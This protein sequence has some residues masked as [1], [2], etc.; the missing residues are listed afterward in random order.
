MPSWDFVSQTEI[1]LQVWGPLGSLCDVDRPRN[2][3]QQRLMLGWR[4]RSFSQGTG[5]PISLAIE[6]APQA[7]III[8]H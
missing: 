4:D 2:R 7:S 8:V 3:T 6:S 1:I 5:I